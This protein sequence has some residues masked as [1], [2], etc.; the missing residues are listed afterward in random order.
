[1]ARAGKIIGA[2]LLTAMLAAPVAA[3]TVDDDVRCLLAS[4]LFTRAEKDP[5]KRQLAMAASAF[6]LGRLDARISNDQ[7][8]TAVSAQAKAMTAA[9]VG[10]IMNNCARRLQVKGLALR[11]LD[12]NQAPLPPAKKK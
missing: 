11:A 1:M 4:N 9:S 5:A 2:A 6:Y 12:T 3:Q 8:K 10:P 7:L